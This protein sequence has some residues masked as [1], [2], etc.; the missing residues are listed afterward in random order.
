MASLDDVLL[1]LGRL[2]EGVE[3]LREDFRDEKQTAHESRAVIH[4]RLDEQARDIASLKTDVAIAG[5]VEAQ[6]RDEV[7][8]LGDKVDAN[9]ATVGPHVE[10]WK[11]MKAVGVGL[12]GLL[13]V[14]GLSVGAMLTWASET[15]ITTIRHWLRIA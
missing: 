15:A 12:V 7:K 6:V 11:R 1:A 4:R 13:A 9:H 3:Q 2:Q 10:D 14:G 8:A 5:K